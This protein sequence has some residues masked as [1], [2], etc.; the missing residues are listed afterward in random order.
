MKIP[1]K[2]S[3]CVLIKLKLT[4]DREDLIKRKR[5]GRG[6]DKLGVPAGGSLLPPSHQTLDDGLHGTVMTID[7]MLK[8]AQILV[9]TMCCPMRIQ[10]VQELLEILTPMSR[11][12]HAW[13]GLTIPCKISTKIRIIGI[14]S[15]DLKC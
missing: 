15:S 3:N 12:L 4:P 13:I 9:N 11:H 8:K 5:D 7:S 14:V 1:I 2:T 6:M 10:L